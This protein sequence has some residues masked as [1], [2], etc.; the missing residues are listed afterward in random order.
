LEISRYGA[1]KELGKIHVYEYDDKEEYI[2]SKNVS[3][4]KYSNLYVNRRLMK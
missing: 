1:V 2:R 4:T 3:L